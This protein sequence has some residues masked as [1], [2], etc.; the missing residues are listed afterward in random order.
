MGAA[1]VGRTVDVARN[2]TG[3]NLSPSSPAEMRARENIQKRGAG[4]Q[5]FMQDQTFRQ[6]LRERAGREMDEAMRSRQAG[7]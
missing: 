6:R 2:Q 5:Q 3:R 7:M 1:N 4:F